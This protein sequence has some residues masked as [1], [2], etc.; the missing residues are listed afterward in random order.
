MTTIADNLQAIRS[1]LIAASAVS[2]RP[3]GGISLLA[4]SK[5]CPASA[6]REAKLA[7]QTRFAESYV[8]EAL[9][10]IEALRELNLEWHYIGPL[11]SNKTRPVA[12]NFAWV[13]SVDRLKTAQRLSAQ[14]SS[15]LPPL[16]ICLQVN[17]GGEH[18]KSGAQPL[19]VPQ[20]AE[21]IA[22]LPQLVLRGLMAVPPP[23][24]DVVF[25]RAC[26]AQLRVLLAQLNSLGLKLDTLSMGMSHDYAAAVAE[27]ATLVRIGT[28]IFGVRIYKEEEKA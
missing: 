16:Q 15:H 18:S 28:A 23:S 3:A 27:G 7:G 26:F 24:E 20:L 5:N 4:V 10:K 11:Q 21:Q 25:Q 1:A 19:E 9:Q 13:H 14:R 8:S 2:G 6:I 22:C 17:I 12:E